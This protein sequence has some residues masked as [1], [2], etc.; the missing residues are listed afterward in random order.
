VRPG[1]PA[2][3]AGLRS[4]DLI[5]AVNERPIES[6]SDFTEAL[7][8]LEPEAPALLLLKRGESVLDVELRLEDSVP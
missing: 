4:G 3:A 6:C 7:D 2:F 1:S 5:L 8:A